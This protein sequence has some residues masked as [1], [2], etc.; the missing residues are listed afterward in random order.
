MSDLQHQN[1]TIG[2]SIGWSSVSLVIDLDG[3]RCNDPCMMGL[4]VDKIHVAVLPGMLYA[5][6]LFVS[7]FVLQTTQEGTMMGLA[8][9]NIHVPLFPGMADLYGCYIVIS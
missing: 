7:F 3:R 6:C 8:V 1:E 4:P 5:C 9:D 2:T